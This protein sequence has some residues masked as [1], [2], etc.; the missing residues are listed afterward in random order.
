M[1]FL[2]LQHDPG[3]H[4]AAFTPLIEAAGH[5]I[6]T[7]QL[8]AGA[9]LPPLD[10]V[11]ALWVMGGAQDVFEEDRFPW[12]VAEKVFI[13]EAVLDRGLPYFGICLGHQ[14]LADALGG[15]CDYGGAE[16]G[17]CEVMPLPDAEL[18]DGMAAP[19]PVAQWHGVQVTDLPPGARLTARSEACPVQGMRVGARA[20]SVQ[21]HPEVLP[22]TI[23]H[24][25]QLPSAA[26][27]LDR[28]FG[29]GGAAVFE[30]QVGAHA[31]I[32]AANVRRL[33]DNWCRAAG[34]PSAPARPA[35][36]EQPT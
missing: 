21:S 6:T 29:P 36:T 33:F 31:E 34:I 5:H 17:V 20:F 25:A 3:T 1:H 12:L 35:S 18:F 16:T 19:F 2:V 13:R 7:I 4:P 26:A 15:R 9:A 27:L 23:T 11:D 24:W 10:G 8:D 28:A 32:F 30:A 22:G 14:L